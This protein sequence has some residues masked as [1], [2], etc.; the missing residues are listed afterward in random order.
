MESLER[1]SNVEVSLTAPTTL[2]VLPP[3]IEY[4]QVPVP[5]AVALIAMPCTAPVSTSLM[6]DPTMDETSCPLFEVWSSVRVVNVGD[7]TVITGASLTEVTV[8]D[9]VLLC[10]LNAAVPPVTLLST[11]LPALPLV[12]SQA[13]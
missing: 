7:A 11:L 12:W 8:I 5:F 13:R 10:E 9:A 3:S 4:C 2:H 1:S 6:V